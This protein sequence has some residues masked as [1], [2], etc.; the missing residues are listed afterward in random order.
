M[1]EGIASKSGFSVVRDYVGHGI[2]KV[3]HDDPMIFHYYDRSQDKIKMAP[4][5]V[6]TIEPMINQGTEQGVMDPDGWTVRTKDGKLSAQWEHTVGITEDGAII[7]TER[8][9]S[10]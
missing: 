10:A 3:M 6:F 4:G 8:Q 9:G 2:G 7:F 1:I 5:L